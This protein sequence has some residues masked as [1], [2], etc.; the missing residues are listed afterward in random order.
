VAP[1]K[2]ARELMNCSLLL[3]GLGPAQH[4]TCDSRNILGVNGRS[5]S[6]EARK[7]NP[8]LFLYRRPLPLRRID[9]HQ[10]RP[11][12]GPLN[13]GFLNH[14]LL[15]AVPPPWTQRSIRLN[16]R[17][18]DD[19]PDAG[20]SGRRDQVADLLCK[21]RNEEQP[22]NSL[23]RRLKSDHVTGC[24]RNLAAALPTID[25]IGVRSRCSRPILAVLA[26]LSAQ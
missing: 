13:A 17:L 18:F 19:M 21:R 1:K 25:S 5:P 9:H 11:G 3:V 22:V 24:G 20:R 16:R 14:L 12:E 26:G 8:V 2:G 15:L 7:G 4:L 6:L 10:R 23:H